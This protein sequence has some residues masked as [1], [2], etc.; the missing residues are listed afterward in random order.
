MLQQLQMGFNETPR[1]LEKSNFIRA[2]MDAM[3]LLTIIF[4]LFAHGTFAW[5]D[6]A[7]EVRCREIGFS[8][9]AE[10]QDLEAFR[11]FI[12]EDARFISSSVL[13]GPDAI[14]AAWNVYFQAGGPTIK[15]RPQVV[16]VL[17]NGRL[18]LSRGPYRVA[19]VDDS[20]KPVEQWGT[21]N[22]VWRVNDD[23]QW[24]VV[25]DAGSPATGSP[26][27]ATRSLLDAEDDCP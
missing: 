5:A 19:A 24:R 15:W 21:F 7:D 9:A 1:A 25:F 27:E 23:G 4:L 18:A 3:R 2:T 17:D 26:D 20:G 13:R 11:S 22:S 6:L 8:R 12:D 14:T 10:R 16:E